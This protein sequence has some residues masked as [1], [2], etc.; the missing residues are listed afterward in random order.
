MPGWVSWAAAIETA[1]LLLLGVDFALL[2]GVLSF[3]FSFVPYIGFIISFLPPALFALLEF[4]LT[5]AAEVVVGYITI[6]TLVDNVLTPKVMAKGLN[7]SPL[8]VILSVLF[9]SWVMGP[10]GAVLSVPMTLM[11]KK[12]V[13]ESSE[14]SRWLAVLME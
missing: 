10:P 9:W 2:W 13:L 14:E 8:V 3:L 1:M 12:L 6:N 5:R 4:D 7:L 11:V